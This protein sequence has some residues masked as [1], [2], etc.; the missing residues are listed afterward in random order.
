MAGLSTGMYIMWAL[1]I[2]GDVAKGVKAFLFYFILFGT[3]KQILYNL[4]DYKYVFICVLYDIITVWL[5]C[6]IYNNM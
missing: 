5:V 4:Y 3:K 6:L 1:I 2:Q